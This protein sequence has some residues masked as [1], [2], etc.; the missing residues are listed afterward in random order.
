MLKKRGSEKDL[1]GGVRSQVCELEPRDDVHGL[2]LLE[3]QLAGVRYLDRGHVFG[4]LSNGTE[5]TVPMCIPIPHEPT[6]HVHMNLR[7]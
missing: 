2:Q 3:Q 7:D 4:R 6:G 5:G 1:C